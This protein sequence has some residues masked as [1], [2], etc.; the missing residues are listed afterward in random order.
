QVDALPALAAVSRLEEER[1]APLDEGSA[2]L[3]AQH[4]NEWHALFG[5]FEKLPGLGAAQFQSLEAFART[6]AGWRPAA[7]NLV[8]GEWHSLVELLALG[9]RAGSLDATA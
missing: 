4:F 3:L 1:H 8:M 7:Q 2:R 6:V 5:Y 9:T